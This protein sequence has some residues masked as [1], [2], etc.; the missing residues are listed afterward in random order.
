MTAIAKP[1]MLK[2]PKKPKK[3][4]GVETWKRYLDRCDEVKRT[5]AKR[6]AEWKS[7]NARAS[8]TRK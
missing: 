7:V 4:A 5:N 6:L 8:R 2:M 1:K 3:R